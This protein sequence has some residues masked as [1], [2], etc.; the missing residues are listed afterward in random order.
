LWGILLKHLRR[1]SEAR[2][3]F[4]PVLSLTQSPAEMSLVRRYLDGLVVNPADA[5]TRA[6]GSAQAVEVGAK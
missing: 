4:Q 5:A 3:A 6:G 1:E 2:D